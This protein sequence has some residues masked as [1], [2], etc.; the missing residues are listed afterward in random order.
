MTSAMSKNKETQNVWKH[1]LVTCISFT[2]WQFEAE[3]HAFPVKSF[4]K[5]SYFITLKSRKVFFF[6]CT[7]NIIIQD[8]AYGQTISWTKSKLTNEFLNEFLCKRNR[9]ALGQIC[10]TMGMISL[11]NLKCDN[12]TL[13]LTHITISCLWFSISSLRK[14]AGS[15][16]CAAEERVR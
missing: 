3:I 10:Q 2:I 13:D 12:F 11:Q 1:V 6:L 15:V 14:L 8:I 7:E 5:N 9:W 4:L 16:L